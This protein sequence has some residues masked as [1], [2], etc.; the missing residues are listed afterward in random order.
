MFKWTKDQEKIL[1]AKGSILVSAS[2][3]TG[4]TSILIEKIINAL[5]TD[6]VG[7]E[8]ILVMTFSKAAA[9]EIKSRMK[10]R[11][12]EKTELC[13]SNQLANKYN[14][15]LLKIDSAN[16]S[17]IHS[18]CYNLVKKYG[19]SIGVNSD[20]KLQDVADSILIKKQI[21]EELISEYMNGDKKHDLYKLIAS[22]DN[23]SSAADIFLSIYD[24]SNLNIDPKGF[25]QDSAKLYDTKNKDQ[26]IKK[27]QDNIRK[28]LKDAEKIYNNVIKKTESINDSKLQKN[29]VGLQDE[30]DQI[31]NTLLDHEHFFESLNKLDIVKQALR[32]PKEYA[33]I[34]NSRDNA[35]DLI[36]KYADFNLESELKNIERAYPLALVLVDVVT[37][38][39]KQYSVYKKENNILDFSDMERYS[40]EILKDR[41][42]QDECQRS[43]Y[44]IFID[45]YQDTSPIQEAI[46]SKIAK[47]DNLFCVGDYKQSIYG[48]RSADPEIFNDR[49]KNYNDGEGQVLFIKDNFRSEKNIIN[50]TNDVFSLISSNSDNFKYSD[51]EKLYSDKMTVESESVDVRLIENNTDETDDYVES[52]QVSSLIKDMM[53]KS[54]EDN[55]HQLK[56]SDFSIVTRK[57]SGIS[58]SLIKAFEESKIPFVIE[59]TGSL[60]DLPEIELLINVL[61]IIDKRSD[62]VAVIS[63]IHAGLFSLQDEDLLLIDTRNISKSFYKCVENNQFNSLGLFLSKINKKK[64][65]SIGSIVASAIKD[66][67]IKGSMYK[68]S[69]ARSRINNINAFIDFSVNYEKSH[70]S[71]LSSFISYVELLKK[72]S[73]RIDTP[74]ENK[75]DAVTITT[76]HRSKGLEY[77]VV[78]IP[79]ASKQF[80]VIDKSGGLTIDEKSGLGLKY[81]D[82]RIKGSTMIKNII[83]DEIMFKNI[84]EEARLLYVAMTRAKEKL[85]IQGKNCKTYNNSYMKWVLKTTE[86]DCNTGNWQLENIEVGEINKSNSGT[87]KIVLSDLL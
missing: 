29:L 47:S 1:N 84:N 22:L 6:G 7:V 4:K 87:H 10:D 69:D 65:D 28:D 17:T 24:K 42:I 56:Y 20:V 53:R 16:I 82:G 73:I 32:F 48:F 68:F 72:N 26:I 52:L 44:Q 15:E 37:E 85:I 30:R 46:I 51:E 38:F 14:S 11:L 74:K 41:A 59:K 70:T 8:N 63:L 86:R 35:R 18:F 12:R 49:I 55:G 34:K 80:S 2:A 39:A 13:K 64:D 27:I 79:F 40:F 67:G 19:Y 33:D 66:S 62:D 58:D 21:M 50:A 61:K 36:L 60:L 76:I 71:S 25:L 83:D 31:Q 3:G 45:E 57:M 5:D 78:I 23:P 75:E 77:P 9:N 54:I 81:C 43:F